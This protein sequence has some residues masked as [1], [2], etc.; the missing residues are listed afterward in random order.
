MSERKTDPAPN[1]AEGEREMVTD[2]PVECWGFMSFISR[3]SRMLNYF[4]TNC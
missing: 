4:T 3:A 1:Q 2:V